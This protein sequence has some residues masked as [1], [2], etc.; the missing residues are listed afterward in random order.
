[1]TISKVAA[2]TAVAS[3]FWLMPATAM[4]APAPVQKTE[5]AVEL[6]NGLVKIG[7]RAS[8]RIQLSAT[9]A[10]I[11]PLTSVDL[12]EV[13]GLSFGAVGGP[14]RT[15]EFGR[16]PRGRM[17]ERTRLTYS[18]PVTASGK[19]SYTIPPL[20]LKVGDREVR[21]PLEPMALE[22]VED[23]VGSRV[24]VLDMEPVP[25]RVFE[26]EPYT[27][28]FTLGWALSLTVDGMILQVPW[29]GRQDGVVSLARSNSGNLVD[30]PI[31][32]G[33]NRSAAMEDLGPRRRDGEEYRLF[34]FER[35]FVGTRPGTIEFGRTILQVNERRNGDRFGRTRVEP[36]YQVIPDFSIEVVPVPEEGRPVDWSGAIGDVQVDREVRRRDIDLGDSI[37]FE[38]SYRGEGNL[39]F[40]DPP[41]LSR[42]AGFEDFRVLGV[43]DRTEPYSRLIEYDLVPRSADVTEIPPVPL[44]VFDTEAESF[45]TIESD[46]VEIRVRPGDPGADDPF[47]GLEKVDEEEVPA[48][49]RDIAARPRSDGGGIPS[50]PSPGA[51]AT[52]LFASIVGWVSLRRYV[53]RKGDPNSVVARRRRGAFRRLKRDL[54]AR[55]A[56][57]DPSVRALALERFLAARTHTAPGSWIGRSEFGPSDGFEP[58]DRLQEEFRNLRTELDGPVF[59]GKASGSA[60]RRRI[61]AFAERAISEGL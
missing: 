8:I 38:L 22:V 11:D 43:E 26:G 48:A 59:G 32:P 19:G 42:V 21:A 6:S 2:R 3:F 46:P 4:A 34:T 1:M 40:F 49:L 18:V 55:E 45:R 16:G 17:T 61:S 13:E 57:S 50:G 56:G 9:N 23:I 7:E 12:P 15:S 51:A 24:L 53:R 52:T 31:G 10:R 35:R 30:F 39:E 36:Y 28:E 47:E 33:R 14:A 5:V 25:E 29:Y 58:S 60:D 37:K 44:T 41:D 27:L 20:T 54:S